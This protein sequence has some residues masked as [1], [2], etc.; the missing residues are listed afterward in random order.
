MSQIVLN[1]IRTPDGA[2][3]SSYSVHDY[4]THVDKNGETY[5]VDG[6]GEYLRRNKNEVPYKEL[7]VYS[8]SPYEEVRGCM[9]W[10]TYGKNS[11]YSRG[12]FFVPL[13]DLSNNHIRAI[14][15]TQTHIS[16][17]RRG[18]FTKELEYRKEHNIYIEEVQDYRKTDTSRCA[19]EQGGLQQDT[20]TNN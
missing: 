12:A 9:H 17:W 7:S 10:G 15:L 3:L 19:T 18:L 16:E 8:D 2:V 4:V 13:K 6:G 14:L 5:M 20:G 11:E 1:R